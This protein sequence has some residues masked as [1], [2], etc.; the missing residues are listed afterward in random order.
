MP[1][2]FLRHQR[3]VLAQ[4]AKPVGSAP[5]RRKGR[6]VHQDASQAAAPRV[7]NSQ[8]PRNGVVGA[9][10]MSR[11]RNV[12]AIHS[13]IRHRRIEGSACRRRAA[14]QLATPSPSPSA[15]QL[16]PR[17]PT[18]RRRACLHHSCLLRT[19]R[20]EN[21]WPRAKSKYPETSTVCA[22]TGFRRTHQI[23]ADLRSASHN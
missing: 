8:I 9:L 15:A 21:T 1:R 13:E 5:R 2:P 23:P 10:L 22:R 17:S 7:R 3:A 16:P 18:R 6:Q 20:R 19:N 12:R 11:P 4:F 14:P